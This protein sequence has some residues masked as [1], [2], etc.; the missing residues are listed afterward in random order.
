MEQIYKLGINCVDIDIDEGK[1]LLFLG[2]NGKI[3]IYD[4][5]ECFYI[6]IFK[7]MLVVMVERILKD[8]YKFSVEI[9]QWYLNDI[10]MFLFSLVDFM[11]KV[12]DIN[13]FEVVEN[14]WFEGMVYYY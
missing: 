7:C 2:L 6:D 3:V 4:I 9:V 10:G 12:W 11:F 13:V 5:E 8:S 1:Y 14:F